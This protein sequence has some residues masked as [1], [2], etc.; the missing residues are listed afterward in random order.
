M[1]GAPILFDL[2]Q[3]SAVYLTNVTLG[4]AFVEEWVDDKGEALWHSLITP[5]PHSDIYFLCQLKDDFLACFPLASF[6]GFY[7]LSWRSYIANLPKLGPL[8]DLLNLQCLFHLSKIN[9]LKTKLHWQAYTWLYL[10][11]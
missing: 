9:L 8:K 2:S 4:S 11:L 6:T 7:D 5:W 3:V 10:H 1:G